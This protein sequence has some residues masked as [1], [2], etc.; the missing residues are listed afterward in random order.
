MSR[1][2]LKARRSRD[3]QSSF[4]TA[5]GAIVYAAVRNTRRI[6]SNKAP[7][8][9]VAEID[10]DDDSKV[11]RTFPA[12]IER[13]KRGVD[14]MPYAVISS[15][16][17]PETRFEYAANTLEEAEA[18]VHHD[19]RLKKGRVR[20]YC[21]VGPNDKK[22]LSRF[23]APELE[24]LI[25]SMQ[26]SAVLP[27][28]IEYNELINRAAKLISEAEVETVAA[29]ILEDYRRT[30]RPAAAQPPVA[31]QS[32]TQETKTVNAAASETAETPRKARG[33]SKGRKKATGKASGK[34]AKGARTPV[35]GKGG[36][37]KSA[38]NKAEGD[39]LGREGTCFRFMAE[40]IMK[41]QD[42]ATI[43]T[44]AKKQFPK[45]R[46]TETK[47]VAWARWKLK[48]NGVNVPE[49]K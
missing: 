12:V 13:Q 49:A 47:H 48:Q 42:N 2:V 37:S 36:S 41:G 14:Q 30:Q 32:N 46:S 34:T 21:I 8:D 39:G 23:Q 26:R 20:D 16:Q 40:R 3:R 24:H 5:Y 4:S 22:L 25:R 9:S 11:A 35:R 43:S 7:Y 28:K 17:W 18:L 31:A 27:D 33:A 1:F 10:D 29:K 6:L 15:R 45:E 19:D 38:T 44:A